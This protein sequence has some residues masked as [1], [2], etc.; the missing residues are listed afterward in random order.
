MAS[1]RDELEQDL[2]VIIN[3][4]ERKEG[5]LTPEEADLLERAETGRLTMDDR[6][7]IREELEKDRLEILDELKAARKSF[8]DKF[9]HSTTLRRG[10]DTSRFDDFEVVADL[11]GPENELSP[12][13]FEFWQR[14]LIGDLTG[15]DLIL[16]RRHR[17]QILRRL[18]KARQTQ[19]AVKERRERRR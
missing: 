9:R 4:L 16:I 11:V 8:D 2:E 19:E 17:F 6:E 5:E 13:H 10:L 15:E 12:E 3:Y 14:A 7:L 1:L 18:A